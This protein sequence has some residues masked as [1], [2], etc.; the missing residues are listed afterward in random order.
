MSPGESVGRRA[1]QFTEQMRCQ[2]VLTLITGFIECI[3]FAGVTFGWASLVFVLKEERYFQNLCPDTR[4]QTRN[5]TAGCSSQDEQFSIVFT[6]AAFTNS[7]IA[8]L[9]G[10]IFDRLGTAVTRSLAI[11][12]YTTA[13]ILIALSTA[14]S[15]V[16]LYPAMSLLATGG[17]LFILTN[18]QVGNLFG[19]QRSTIITFYNG[20]FDSSS[21]IFL[22]VKV[23]YQNGISL[24]IQFLFI[25]SCSVCHILRTIFLMPKTHI[26]FP[27]P[28]EYNYGLSCAKQDPNTSKSKQQFTRSDAQTDTNYH[29]TDHSVTSVIKHEKNADVSFMSCVC[30]SLFIW[31]LVWLSLMQL[32]HYLFIGTLNPVITRL[33]GG[34]PDIVSKYTNVFAVSQFFGV[35]CAPWN[36]LIM[37]RHKGKQKDTDRLDDIH[38][39]ILSL[40]LTTVL[41]VLFSV[42]ASIPTLPALYPTFIFQVINRS[43]LYGGNAAFLSIV[44]PPRYFGKLYGLVMALSALISTLQYAAFYIIRTHLGG[45]PFYVNIFLLILM[46]LTFAHPINIFHIWKQEKKA[47]E[48]P[49]RKYGL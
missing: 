1:S 6:V 26:P 22:I 19:S 28:Q 32:R 33:S 30:S 2:R 42:C 20:A 16:L 7:F 37:D 31:H 21:V 13:T 34:D 25:S 39:S 23:L 47:K 10:Y 48:T 5:A 45:D 8:L 24:R 18:M 41:G 29:S 38:S 27:L 17:V 12:F 43:F 9:C 44:F 40:S 46:L 11:L 4:N 3:C 36:G 14:D 35:L 49:A 15:A